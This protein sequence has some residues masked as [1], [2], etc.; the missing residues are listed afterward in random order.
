MCAKLFG[1]KAPLSIII[2]YPIMGLRH[3]P[4]KLLI[5]MNIKY[6]TFDHSLHF[7]FISLI[8]NKVVVDL[9]RPGILSC[10]SS[11]TMLPWCVLLCCLLTARAQQ[12]TLITGGDNSPATQTSEIYDPASGAQCSLTSMFPDKR[13]F[14]TQV[15]SGHRQLSAHNRDQ[16]NWPFTSCQSLMK[17]KRL[18]KG[19]LA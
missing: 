2:I 13:F 10:Q 17:P 14:H 7:L 9:N 18:L 5:S 4:L 16:I 6:V 11:I 1:V 12:V 19:A 15:T 3:S 8:F